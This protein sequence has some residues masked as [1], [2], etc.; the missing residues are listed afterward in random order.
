MQHYFFLAYF[1]INNAIIDRTI[2][3]ITTIQLRPINDNNESG[4]GPPSKSNSTDIY[5]ISDFFRKKQL[6]DILQ[7]QDISIIIRA[8][9]ADEYFKETESIKPNI[10]MGG[11]YS[12]WCRDI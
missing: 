2:I 7:N 11:L 12:D 10:T 3:P 6:L 9:R 8:K 5:K 4:N 1:I